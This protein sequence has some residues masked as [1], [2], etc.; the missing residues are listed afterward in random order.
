[1]PNTPYF[2]WKMTVL[3]EILPYPCGIG[4]PMDKKNKYGGEG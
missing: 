3:F 2:I 1:M 4:I